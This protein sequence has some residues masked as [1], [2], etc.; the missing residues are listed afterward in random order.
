MKTKPLKK[1]LEAQFYHK[2]IPALCLAVFSSLIGGSLNLIVSWLI[3]QL[4][5]AA[6]GVPGTL[7][8]GT[9]AKLS[10]GFVVLCI[11][12][13][14]LEYIS[15]PLYI[16][17]AMLQY[18]NFAF[19]KL[20]EKGISSFRD[21]STATYLSALTN[22][23][24]SIETDYL[25]QQMALISKV[26]TFAGALVMMLWYSPLLTAIAAGVTILPLIA[27]LLTGSRIE[28]AERRVSDRNRSFTAALSDCLAG[29]SVVKSFKAEK[30]IFKLFAEN[31]RALEG[32]K[33]SKRRIK[34]I[35]GM[36]GTVTGIIAQLGTPDMKLPIQYALYYPERRFLPGE[37]LDFWEL[38]QITFERPDMETFQ[39][40]LAAMERALSERTAAVLLNSPNNPSGAVF[41]RESL[42][43]VARLLE[44]KSGE[45]GHPIY[46]IA[47]EPYR[48]LV[49]GQREVSFLPAI[50]S[51][52]VY[53]YSFSKSLS[54]PGERVGFLA[55]S[56]Q[57]A[58]HDAVMA[59]INGAARALGYI[60]V[61]SLFQRVVGAC[62]GQT[63]DLAVY[64]ENRNYIYSAL[65]EL[66]YSCVRPDGAFY[67][68]IRTP[69]EPGAFC[70]QAMSMDLLLI[71]GEEFYCPGYARLAY[72][73]PKEKLER[74]VPVFR[75]LAQRFGL[76][77]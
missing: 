7:P 57:A 74:S 18:K 13:F 25:G 10:G 3:M 35:V 28:A 67:L 5:D 50:Y 48:E 52:T 45:Y 23:S 39:V 30:E 24:T 16:E 66:G 44:R 12:V 75:T 38:T 53:C 17:R 21:E 76:C 71:P 9:L 8:I 62:I 49:Y 15:M 1:Q 73:V 27:S 69:G 55:V 77:R 29:F 11:A 43:A 2:N 56:P 68:F 64:E 61:S 20:T 60:N 58:E 31:N 42:T 65:T 4:I 70:S 26:F 32:E 40:D 47:D 41:S 22:D 14:L 37:R 6:S 36:I 34:T 51:D 33:F 46:L 19:R 59:A 63:A 54:L 72:C